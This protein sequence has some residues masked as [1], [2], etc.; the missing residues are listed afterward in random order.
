MCLVLVYDATYFRLLLKMTLPLCSS[1]EWLS[2]AKVIL[3]RLMIP[4]DVMS[5]FARRVYT[6]VYIPSFPNKS[7][8]GKK[9]KAFHSFIPGSKSLPET[10][11]LW[12]PLAKYYFCNFSGKLGWRLLISK[13][14]NIHLFS[15][16]TSEYRLLKFFQSIFWWV[17]PSI[18]DWFG[19]KRT[20]ILE[21][22]FLFVCKYCE[23]VSV[24]VLSHHCTA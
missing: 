8:E 14:L 1:Y 4:V 9:A 10:L 12:W 6:Y 22:K 23:I 2:A 3:I 21:I 11:L 24:P 16:E 19:C 5:L 20:L 17:R 18:V 13:S 7:A 15:W